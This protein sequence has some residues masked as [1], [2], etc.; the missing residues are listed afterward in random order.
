MNHGVAWEWRINYMLGALGWRRLLGKVFDE[1][2]TWTS[3][4]IVRYHILISWHLLETAFLD[5]PFFVKLEA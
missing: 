4:D 2:S 5:V 1:I 3:D